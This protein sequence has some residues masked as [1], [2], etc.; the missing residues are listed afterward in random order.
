MSEL[1]DLA[2]KVALITGA[3]GRLGSAIAGGLSEAGAKVILAG[4]DLG[5]L[6]SAGD[7][8]GQAE[9]RQVD[10]LHE[11]QIEELFSGLEGELDIL[12][13]CAGV[14]SRSE[15]GAVRSPDFQEVLQLNVVGGYLCAQQAA[16]LMRERGG[17]KV[18]N[19]GSIYGAVAPDDRIYE[20]APGMVRA[21]APYIASKSALVNL[22][23][24]LAVRLASWNVQVNMVSPGGV[25][26]D[27]PE[28]FKERYAARTP[29]GRMAAPRDVVGTVVYLASPASD[30]V[31]GQNI[32]VDGGFTS[33]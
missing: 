30:Y 7:A 32:L 12:V 9:I 29:A 22:T 28:S 31:T 10:L 15:F 8:V 1:F 21:A 27:Q 14:A 33:W 20:D 3:G 11:D 24:E 25:E 2:G 18:V 23:R 13:N 4:R 17:G 26:A 6:Q 16:P 19:V 5:R